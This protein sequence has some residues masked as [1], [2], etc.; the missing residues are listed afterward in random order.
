MA[1]AMTTQMLAHDVRKLFYLLKTTLK[2]LSQ[3]KDPSKINDLINETIPEIDRTIK[4]VEGL[5]KDILEIGRT[6]GNLIL[7]AIDPESFIKS[8]IKENMYIYNRSNINFSFYFQHKHMFHIHPAKMERVFSNILTNAMQAM[9]FQGNI[10]IH[11]KEIIFN[12]KEY[13]EFC[14]GN[15]NSYISNENTKKVFNKFYTQKQNGTGLGLAI[16]ENL[17][18]EHNGNIYCTSEKN[19]Q[20]PEGKVEFWFTLPVAKGYLKLNKKSLGESYV[21]SGK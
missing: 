7:A 12:T 13:I 4:K 8:I 20:Y 18:K 16:V 15:N 17:I 6:D 21:E 2:L 11:S 5:L 1:I 10:W 19:S 9:N 14:I 3:T